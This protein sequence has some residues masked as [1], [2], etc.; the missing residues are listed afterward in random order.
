[1]CWIDDDL[2][3]D[4]VVV[5]MVHHHHC[6]YYLFGGCSLHQA[7]RRCSPRWLPSWHHYPSQ[8]K[9]RKVSLRQLHPQ[10]VCVGVCAPGTCV[11]S[12]IAEDEN[13]ATLYSIRKVG[14]CKKKLE[15][16]ASTTCLTLTPTKVLVVDIDSLLA[17]IVHNHVLFIT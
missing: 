17:T 12:I 4:V 7:P 15:D 5:V 3:L 9:R 6:Y 2:L 14:I 16:S 11:H 10:G 1:M 8:E 13:C